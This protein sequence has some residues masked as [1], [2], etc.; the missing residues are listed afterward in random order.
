MTN[1]ERSKERQPFGTRIHAL[2]GSA[3]NVLVCIPVAIQ[4]ILIFA[5]GYR[6]S[7][8]LSDSKRTGVFSIL[9]MGS[10]TLLFYSV[11]ISQETGMTALS[12]LAL[13]YFL[14]RGNPCTSGDA[15]LA[16]FAA[17]LGALSREYG[18]YSSYAEQS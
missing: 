13:V 10:S 6:L 18:G 9:L 3:E 1:K 7:T 8:A 15:I 16:A 11:M 5:F 17:S 12:M 2:F 4:Y 14:A